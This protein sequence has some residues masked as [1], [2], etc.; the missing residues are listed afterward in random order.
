MI[1]AG[2]KEGPELASVTSNPSECVGLEEFLEE[3]L[4]KVFG[5]LGR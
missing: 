3:G 2:Q 4:G 1:H 5:V